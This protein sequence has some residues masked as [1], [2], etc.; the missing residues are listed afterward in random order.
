MISQSEEDTAPRNL[1]TLFWASPCGSVWREFRGGARATAGVVTSASH[2]HLTVSSAED[3]GTVGAG[4]DA[5]NAT[6]K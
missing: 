4:C 1:E 2:A 5:G 6:R 3:L